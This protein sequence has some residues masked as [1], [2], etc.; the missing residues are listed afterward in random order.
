MNA[1]SEHDKMLIHKSNVLCRR[2]KGFEMDSNI[3]FSC[4]E[5]FWLRRDKQPSIIWPVNDRFREVL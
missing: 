5:K 4:H 3:L 1:E 2:A